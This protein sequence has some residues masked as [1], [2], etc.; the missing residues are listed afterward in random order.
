M[1]HACTIIQIGKKRNEVMIGG[2]PYF[3][4]TMYQKYGT[5]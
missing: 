4:I 5:R 2:Y 1:K 3:K